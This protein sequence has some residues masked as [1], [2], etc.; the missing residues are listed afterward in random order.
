M[1][2][3]MM[4]FAVTALRYRTD[5]Q[6]GRPITST[7]RDTMVIPLRAGVVPVDAKRQ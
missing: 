4:L 3:M 1:M 5:E 6:I 2:M 7:M